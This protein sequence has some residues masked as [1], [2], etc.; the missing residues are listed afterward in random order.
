M[1]RKTK[2]ILIAFLTILLLGAGGIAYYM[3]QVYEDIKQKVTEV[4]ISYTQEAPRNSSYYFS[5]QRREEDFDE[6]LFQFKEIR[7][8]QVMLTFREKEYPVT[9]HIVDDQKPVIDFLNT[10]IDLYQ[11]FSINELYSVHDKTQ[12]A[13]QVNMQEADF[14]LGEHNFCV[15]ASD[16]AG[17]TAEKCTTMT[18]KD[19]RPKVN[20][21][22]NVSFDY[23]YANMSLEAILNDY[24]TKRGLTSQIAVSYYNFVTKESFFIHPDQWMIAG[25][26][27]KLPLNMYYYE[28][29]NAGKI[30]QSSKLLYREESFEENGPIG[31]YLY[32][33]GDEISISELQYYSIVYSDNT[34]SRILF[35][36]LG[37]WGP[38][39]EAIKKYSSLT[40]YPD[41]FYANNF[42]VRYMNDVLIY[43]YQHY[44]SFP[45]LRDRMF[46][47]A[48]GLMLKRY[49]N[50]PIMQKD[51]CYGS[52]YNT[53]G[54]V[55]GDKPYAVAV[56]TSLGEA[57]PNIIGEIN[58]LL[59]QYAQ[60]H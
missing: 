17:N 1:K 28:L 37:G 7:D 35:D 20:L 10:Q 43:L 32:K 22:A 51:G 15:T 18:V 57:G 33:P 42:S 31:D 6:E 19:S 45:E 3:T 39:R 54:L 29:E 27:Y 5:G 21:T 49:V 14:T 24:R 48:P 50:V 56:Y 12:T 30:S 53:A 16:T 58:L 2:V 38:Y 60:A 13:V 26:T 9:F 11:G 59:Y 44:N 34:A 41:A 47:V 55:F 25:S 4:A 23:D 46:G 8:Y 52:A 40:A 36:G